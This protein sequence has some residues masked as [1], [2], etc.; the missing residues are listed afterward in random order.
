M[1]CKNRFCIYQKQNQCNINPI[2]DELEFSETGNCNS[3]IPF[4][5]KEELL[6]ELKEKSR[7]YIFY[8]T[9]QLMQKKGKG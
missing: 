7:S 3:F 6:D 8:I 9:S 4:D 5:I 1:I 2:F